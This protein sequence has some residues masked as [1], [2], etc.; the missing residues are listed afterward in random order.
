[1]C[2]G[3]YGPTAALLPPLHAAAQRPPCKP[4]LECLCQA[5]A[6][7]QL[8]GCRVFVC[9]QHVAGS[10][11]P[12][13]LAVLLQIQYAEAQLECRRTILLSHFGETFN[14]ADCKGTCDVCK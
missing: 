11:C 7:G 4:L 14:A 3:L 12:T 1:M 8:H 6:R 2:N 10:T 13:L 5:A 9:C